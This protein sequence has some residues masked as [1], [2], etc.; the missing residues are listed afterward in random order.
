LECG[1]DPNVQGCSG[2]VPLHYAA[3]FGHL[4]I[5]RILLNSGADPN[6]R[7]RD[8]KTPLDQAI[9]SLKKI[10]ESKEPLDRAIGVPRTIY[11]RR[12]LNARLKRNF[13]KI[14]RL[15]RRVSGD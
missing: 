4:G 14:I 10:R 9:E 13:D 2:D 1:A 7:N 15:L 8:G 6:I 5:V 11:E 3:R 12:K